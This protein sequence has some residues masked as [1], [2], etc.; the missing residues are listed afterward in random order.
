MYYALR[1]IKLL[2][3]RNPKCQEPNSKNYGM[4]CDT[5]WDLRPGIWDLTNTEIYPFC[6]TS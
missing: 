6:S 4:L 2:L 3:K 1:W 5:S